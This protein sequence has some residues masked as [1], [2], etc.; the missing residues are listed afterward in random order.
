MFPPGAP[1]LPLLTERRDSFL[2]MVVKIMPYTR[3]SNRP[4]RT[5][6]SAPAPTAFA[7]S[8][9]KANMGFLSFYNIDAEAPK[10]PKAIFAPTA[11]LFL[12]TVP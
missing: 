11:F 6:P 10:R 4:D 8:S 5:G 7:I 1:L 12:S 2:F 3:P 9:P